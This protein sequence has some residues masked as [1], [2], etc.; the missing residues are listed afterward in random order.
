LLQNLW[1][2]F[3]LIP[4]RTLREVISGQQWIEFVLCKRPVNI[5]WM[6]VLFFFFFFLMVLWFELRALHL[7]DKCSITWATPP[8]LSYLGYFSGRVPLCPLHPTPGLDLLGTPILPVLPMEMGLPPYP[9]CLL[10]WEDLDNFFA[11]DDLELWSSWPL[12]PK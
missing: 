1:F 2:P 11:Q 8:A 5:N 12:P 3:F 6:G 4:L 9:A 7:P 10:R